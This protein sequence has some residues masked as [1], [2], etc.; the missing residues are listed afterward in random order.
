MPDDDPRLCIVRYED[1]LDNPL[2]QFRGIASL[3]GIRRGKEI[4]KAVRASQFNVLK[5]QES[6]S[7]CVENPNEERVFFRAGR[8][9][10]WRE[11]LT[12]GQVERVVAGNRAMMEKFR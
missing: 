3:I 7:G 5:Q 9:G 2:K 12:T 11:V 8:Q 4:E 6:K 10:Q 1:L